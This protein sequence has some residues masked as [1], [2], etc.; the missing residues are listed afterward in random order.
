M[1]IDMAS[2][3]PVFS[4]ADI[5]IKKENDSQRVRIVERSSDSS[6]ANLELKK[7]NF[8]KTGVRNNYEGVGDTYSTKGQLLRDRTID[9]N[10][11]NKYLRVD[12]MI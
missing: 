12:M 6:H 2:M 10:G 8:M 9:T 7:E 5:K 4:T 11:G 1:F 3:I